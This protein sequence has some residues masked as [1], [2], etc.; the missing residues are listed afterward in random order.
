MMGWTSDRARRFLAG[1]LL[2]VA[3]WACSQAHAQPPA[4]DTP[5]AAPSAPANVSAAAASPAAASTPAVAAAPRANPGPPAAVPGEILVKFAPTAPADKAATVFATNGLQSVRHFAPIDVHVCRVAPGGDVETALRTCRADNAVVYA[6]PNYIYT[7][8]RTPNDPRF[9]ELWGLQAAADAD[10]DAPEAWDAQTGAAQVLVAIIDT[11]VDYRH[12]DLRANIW[13]NPGESGGGRETNG[14]DDDGNGFVDDVHGWDF[15]GDDNDPMDDN[16]HGSHVAGTIAAAGD[17]RTGVVGVNWRASIMGCKF[18]DANGSGSAA[19]AIEAILYA[20]GRGARVLNNSWGGGGFSQ[21]LRDAI[22]F[23][24]QQNAVFVA[25]A[26]N[27]S[28]DNDAFPSYPASYE[29]A[30]VLSI[31]ASDRADALASFSNRGKST[32]DLAAPGVEVLSTT[33]GNRY[34]AFS[35]TSMATP[36]ASGVAA[37]LVAQAPQS[38]YQEILIR[39]AGSV[40]PLPAFTDATWSGGRLNAAAA[41]A[42]GPKVAFVTRL[43][44]T[45][46]LVGPYRVEAQALS[47]STLTG[48]Q[49]QWAVAGGTPTVVPMQSTADHTYR[50]E[51]PT[52]GQGTRLEYFVEV[53]DAGGRTARSRTYTYQ[54]GENAGVPGCGQFTLPSVRTAP[55]RVL[56]VLGNVLLLLLAVAGARRITAARHSHVVPKR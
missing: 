11:G 39:M 9:A 23:A 56:V 20:A 31:A 4:P 33:P 16:G 3:W 47:D 35:G 2:V 46:G 40:D 30:N 17:N 37:L 1:A 19:D 28:R 41:L 51:I 26:G 25:A 49:L 55:G 27:E 54:V 22:E 43:D 13:S 38:T 18:L 12:E 21:A 7:A 50:A 5:A 8:S 52:Q 53:A 14:R 42:T 15:A 29:V 32:V 48:L 6:E 45:P 36:H 44:A 24:R 34:Q 10:I